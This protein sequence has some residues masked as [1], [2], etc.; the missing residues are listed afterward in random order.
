[1]L[2]ILVLF[3]SK[4]D[5]VVY[6]NIIKILKKCKVDYEL[7]LSSAH[8]NPDYVDEIIKNTEYDVIISGAGLSAALPGAI[9]AK[10]IKPVI[11]VPVK[12]NYEGLD[13]L[14]AIAQMPPGVPVLAVGVNKAEIAAKSAIK[15]LDS[16]NGVTIITDDEENTAVKKA[17]EIL[18]SFGINYKFDKSHDKSTIN[19]EFAY[20]DEPIEKKDELVIYCPLL[21]EEDHTADAAL[22]FLKHTTH[23]LWVGLNNGINAALAA[24]EIL[25]RDDKFTNKLNEYRQSMKEKIN[26]DDRDLRK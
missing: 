14:L 11:G 20:F 7:R 17:V 23:G 4:S 22:N 25:N 2:K 8:K 3:A 16:Y 26:K 18:K 5:S 1:M 9:S 21:L 12:N 15:M 24:I 19:L 10:T 13:S 6:K